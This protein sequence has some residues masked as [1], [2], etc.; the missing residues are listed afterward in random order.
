MTTITIRLNNSAGEL[1]SK[2][3]HVDGDAEDDGCAALVAEALINMIHEVGH[4]YPGD[5]FTVEAG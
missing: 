2:R 1:D 5:S 3:L 4:I